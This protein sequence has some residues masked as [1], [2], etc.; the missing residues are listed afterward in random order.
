[1]FPVKYTTKNTTII[2]FFYFFASPQICDI[3]SLEGSLYWVRTSKI[4]QS[5]RKYCYFD[6]SNNVLSKMMN[7]DPNYYFIFSKKNI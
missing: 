7:G 6:V 1:M 4:S 5:P 3:Y 2:Y